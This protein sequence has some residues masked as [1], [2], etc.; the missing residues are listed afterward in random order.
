MKIIG[1]GGALPEGVLTNAD[2]E[3]MVDTSDEWIMT[4]TGIRER[5]ISKKE[6]EIYPLAL[7]A[8]QEAL[9]DAG[10]DPSEISLIIAHSVAGASIVPSLACQLMTGLDAQCPAF[11]INAA[12]T[13]F[14]YAL[15]IAQSMNRGKTLIVCAE[16]MSRIVDYTDRSMCVLFGDAAGAVLLEPGEDYLH[17][18][19]QA[20]QDKLGALRCKGVNAR[21][22]EGNSIPSY[23]HMDGQEVFKFATRVM[24]AQVKEGLERTSLTAD[25]IKYVVP[26]QANVRIIRSCSERSGIPLEKFYMNID[27]TGN[28]SSASIPYA[29]YELRKDGKVS[30]GD[31]VM[32]VGFGGGWTSGCAVVRL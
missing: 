30:A 6:D 2:L 31:V 22:E 13:G 18:D 26:H 14:I 19:I 28:T 32:F 9:R 11:D 4:R 1:V 25:D 29:L 8:A 24:M 21:D 3:K 7:K 16:Q 15:S 12:C 5:R 17:I 23:L 27:R 20:A 10:T